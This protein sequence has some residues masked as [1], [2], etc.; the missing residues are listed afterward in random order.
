MQIFNNKNASNHLNENYHLSNK[1][2]FIYEIKFYC[3]K[4]LD[5][6]IYYKKY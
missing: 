4:Y 1:K 5:L 3:N 2:G 6:I